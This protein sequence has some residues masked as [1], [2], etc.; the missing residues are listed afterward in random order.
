MEAKEPL[1][2]QGAIPSTG[3][4]PEHAFGL[5]FAFEVVSSSI[6]HLVKV[7]RARLQA[8]LEEFRHIRTVVHIMAHALNT[9]VEDIGWLWNRRHLCEDGRHILASVR[10]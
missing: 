4:I 3:S 8:I 6:Q 10:R 7:G 9:R 2:S 1:R 5:Q